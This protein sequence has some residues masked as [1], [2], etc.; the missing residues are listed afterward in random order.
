MKT[1]ATSVLDDLDQDGHLYSDELREAVVK[2]YVQKFRCQGELASD[3]LAEVT[4][5]IA[6]TGGATTRAEKMAVL[7]QIRENRVLR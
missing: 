2:H 1:S 7:K 3:S 4:T 6:G 5:W